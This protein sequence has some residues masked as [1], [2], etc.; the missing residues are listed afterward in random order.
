MHN[1][2]NIYLNL[3]NLY[4]I[5]L[6]CL[7]EYRVTPWLPL[8]F[9]NIYRSPYEFSYHV[10]RMRYS[11]RCIT[12]G[13]LVGEEIRLYTPLLSSTPSRLSYHS[14]YRCNRSALFIHIVLLMPVPSIPITLNDSAHLCKHYL[15]ISF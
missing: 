12:F 13:L 8:A 11:L 10:C 14:A 5:F 15:H 4:E 9:D 2:Y 6:R 3:Y 7:L 1:M